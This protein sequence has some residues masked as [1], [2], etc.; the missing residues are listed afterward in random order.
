MSAV[1]LECVI[2]QL[3]VTHL[4]SELI[5]HSVLLGNLISE[6]ADFLLEG[7]ETICQLLSGGFQQAGELNLNR[8]VIQTLQ[9]GQLE[10][11]IL[12]I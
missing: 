7:G 4:T 6:S 3:Q 1:L 8:G 12:L 5:D 10:G 9:E 2:L 11:L